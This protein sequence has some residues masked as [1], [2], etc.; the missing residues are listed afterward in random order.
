M[1]SASDV[2]E[3]LGVAGVAI[4]VAAYVP[5]LFTSAANTVLRV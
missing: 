3:V 1:V 2:V 4:A 5:Q